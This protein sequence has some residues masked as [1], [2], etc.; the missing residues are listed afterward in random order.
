M[1]PISAWSGCCCRCSNHLQAFSSSFRPF[2][3]N[4]L[5]SELD[6]KLYVYLDIP[7][8][9]RMAY[10]QTSLKS[11]TDSASWDKA[12]AQLMTT[13]TLLSGQRHNVLSIVL[14]HSPPF[15]AVSLDCKGQRGFH[16][17]PRISCEHTVSSW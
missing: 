14:N 1:L 8:E 4:P 2:C 17:F 15:S 13:F 9:S 5:R 10:R 12:C 3:W 6:S 7:S 11:S 16:I